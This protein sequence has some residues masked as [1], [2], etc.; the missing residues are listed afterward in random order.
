MLVTLPFV[1]LLLDYWPLHRLTKGSAVVGK[2]TARHAAISHQWPVIR[3]S[4]KGKDSVVCPVRSFVRGDFAGT[5]PRTRRNRS[6]AVHV[7]AEQCTYELLRLCLADVLSDTTGGLLPSSKQSTP[8]LAS[9][10]GDD[11]SRRVQSVGYSFAKTVSICPDWLVL[12]RGNASARDRSGSG[13][14]TS[15]RRPLYL[16]AQIGLYVIIAWAVADFARPYRNHRIVLAVAAPAAIAAL[17]FCAF[18]QTSYW[19]NSETLWTHALAVTSDNDV[20]HNNLGYLSLRRGELDE[21]ISHFNTALNIRAGNA[22][23]HYNLGHALIENNLANALARKGQPG[24]A[25]PH[26]EEATRLRPDYADAY[27]NFGTVLF[28]EGKIDDAIAEWQKALAIQPYDAE[29]HTS[30][31]SAFGRKGMLREAITEYQ[32]ALKVAPQNRLAMNNLAWLLATSS[33]ASIRDGARAVAL[34]REAVAFDR[35]RSKLPP[36]TGGCLRGERSIF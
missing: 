13:R 34:A 35:W 4:R 15:A 10:G 6:I 7:A 33:D 21:A 14:G 24:E 22:A 36:D 17:S 19:K 23:S 11:V 27:Y 9:S 28:R 18:V 16:P 32:Q 31:G 1:L 5:T 20:A 26:Y 8:V 12:V 3:T 30:L 2:A 29:A 25:I